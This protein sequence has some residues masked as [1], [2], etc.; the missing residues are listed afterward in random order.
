MEEKGYV[1]PDPN[2]LVGLP[3]LKQAQ[4]LCAQLSLCAAMCACAFTQAGCKAPTGSGA[5]WHLA[6]DINQ[7]NMI[8]GDSCHCSL[9]GTK[10]T[11]AAKLCQAVKHLFGDKLLAKL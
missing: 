8:P 9:H 3:P 2:S 10:E 11:K 5:V 4:K 7:V 6:M 1:F